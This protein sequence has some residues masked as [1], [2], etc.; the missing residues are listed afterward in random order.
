MICPYCSIGY[1]DKIEETLNLKTSSE[2]GKSRTIEVRTCPECGRMNLTLKSW[3][4]YNRAPIC[5]MTFLM[6][7]PTSTNNRP[8]CPPEVPESF[9][10][11]YNEACAC[12]DLA[13]SPKASAALSRRC[14]QN[15]LREVAKVKHSNL[16][17]EIDEIIKR[18]ELPS[19]LA[20][21]IDAI[22]GVG[23]FAA[24][25]IKSENTGEI[26]PVEVGEAELSLSILEALFDFYFVRPAILAKKTAEIDKKMIE[27]G[28]N[29][30][31]KMKKTN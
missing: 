7:P 27:S 11:D 25:P 8:P 12:L 29:P 26:I 10:Q 18:N 3:V 4:Y 31:K 21:L 14:L 16:S 1:H 28:K 19:D 23:N 24:H 5:D 20:D 22:R 6:Y 17:N 2:D 13:N 9:S 30:L 15:L